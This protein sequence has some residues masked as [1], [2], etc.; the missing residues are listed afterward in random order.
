[1][2]KKIVLVSAALL[3]S[4]SLV[5]CST[6]SSSKSSSKSETLN[7][8]KQEKYY[9]DGKTA[10]LHDVKVEITKTKVI[11]PGEKGNEDGQKPLIAFWYKAT[12]LSDKDI[13]PISAWD[14]I[15]HVYQDNDKNKVNE[16]KT[17]PLPDEAYSDSQIAKIKKN[18]TVENAVSYELS[19]DKTPVTLKATKG[20]DNNVLGKKVYK[21][22]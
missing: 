11:N 2:I 17:G 22:K 4:I 10:K 19:D 1:M 13:D 3:V 16:L 5:G 20:Y 15:F 18:G 12:N 7:K 6:N 8:P 14:A 21:L 9:F